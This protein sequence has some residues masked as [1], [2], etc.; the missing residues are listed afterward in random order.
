MVCLKRFDG[1][2]QLPILLGI[3]YGLRVDCAV[4]RHIIPVDSSDV[5]WQ[6][7]INLERVFMVGYKSRPGRSLNQT[8][9]SNGERVPPLFLTRMGTP[10]TKRDQQ[11]RLYRH[12][13]RVSF[14]S[15]GIASRTKDALEVE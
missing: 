14:G 5:V 6:G 13:A 7:A 4:V 10:C 11:L 1:V 3:I 2:L 12:P 9:V 8:G 15:Y